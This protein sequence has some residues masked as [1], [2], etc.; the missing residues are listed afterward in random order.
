MSS[1]NYSA[2]FVSILQM[3]RNEVVFSPTFS[4]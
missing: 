3:K 1:G 2:L 4:G